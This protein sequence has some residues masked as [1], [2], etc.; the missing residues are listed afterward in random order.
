MLEG[1]EV[2]QQDAFAQVR[3]VIELI[4]RIKVPKAERQYIYT[5]L[6]SYRQSINAF[7]KKKE[8]RLSAFFPGQQ[9][10]RIHPTHADPHNHLYVRL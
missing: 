8:Y 7:S 10:R 5:I 9:L 1:E 4:I 3:T 2:I 6:R